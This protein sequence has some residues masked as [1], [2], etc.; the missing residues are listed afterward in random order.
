MAQVIFGE[1]YDPG[2]REL[3]EDRVKTARLTTASGLDL[4]IGAVADGVGG[5]NKGEVA[6]QEALNAF[7]TCLQNSDQKRVQDVLVEAAHAANKAVRDLNRDGTS[8]TLAVAA[9]HNNLLYLAN[10][11]DSRIYLCR[12][13]KLT[14]LTIDHNFAT[15]MPWRGRLSIEA[16]EQHPS[17]D[18][19]MNAL[20]LDDRVMVD[21]GFYVSTSDFAEANARA[22][23]GLPLK[24]GDSILIC[25]DGLVKRSKKTRLAP[26]ETQQIIRILNEQEGKQAAKVLVGIASGNKAQDNVSVAVLQTVDSRRHMRALTR[27]YAMPVGIGVFLL[28]ALLTVFILWNH[29]S[30]QAGSLA[31]AVTQTAQAWAYITAVVGS[32]T[33]TPIPTLTPTPTLRPTLIAG[34]IGKAFTG[35]RFDQAFLTEKD[36]GS[37]DQRLTLYINHLNQGDP[38]VVLEEAGSRV[39]FTAVNENQM[40]FL[41]FPGSDLFIETGRYPGGAKISLGQSQTPVDFTVSGSCMTIRFAANKGA[42]SAA[43]Y[44]GVCTYSINYDSNPVTF[45]PGSQVNIDLAA[46]KAQT[47]RIDVMQAQTYRFELPENSAAQGCAQ[48]Y[49]PTPTPKPTKTPI[50]PPPKPEPYGG[51]FEWNQRNTSLL[52]LSGS[53]FGAFNSESGLFRVG[54]M[55]TLLLTGLYQ[56]FFSFVRNKQ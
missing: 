27:V 14:Q 20:G 13:G 36:L 18:V 48:I 34:E 43:C 8:S 55:L 46:A 11:G 47:A 41:A 26:I 52:G 15:V 54:I 56:I 3:Y 23:K 28:A 44:E 16:A 51:A 53:S 22:E 21:L 9:I 4:V 50:P 7:F 19:L 30:S 17:R 24:E 12:N 6:A 32:Y 31:N 5:E 10:V 1:Q 40:Q 42:V 45:E 39:R 35:V 33:P 38:A 49:A 37:P 29:A 2:E 25:S